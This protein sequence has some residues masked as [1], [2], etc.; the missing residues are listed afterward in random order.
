M[1][2][3]LKV[4][5]L[6][7]ATL[8]TSTVAFSQTPVVQRNVNLRRDPSTSV[9]PITL[10]TPP[11]ALTL[12]DANPQTGY[13]HVRTPSGQEGWVWSKNISLTTASSTPTAKLGPAEL[14]PD[15]TK[16]PGVANPDIT[17]DNIA[18]NICSLNWSTSTIRPP[19]SYTTPLKVQQM[20]TYGDTVSDSSATCMLNSNNKGCYEEDH[21]ISLENGGHPRDPKN[22]WPEPYKTKI[23]GAVVGARQKD[24]VEGF[25]HDEI[26]FD[27]PNHKKNS[28]KPAH[29]SITLKRGQEILTSDW[30]ACYVSVQAGGACR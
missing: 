3:R 24:I 26:C 23:N 19:A 2:I 9:A 16:T 11:T 18:D 21:L 28:N 29:S 13:Y 30:Y 20:V 22:L 17:Q 6:L 10:L 5:L 27:I 4:R 14:Y 12:L 25:I 15:S 1:Q 8:V 7:L